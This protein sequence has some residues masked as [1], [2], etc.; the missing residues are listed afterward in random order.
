[1]FA[2]HFF[3]KTFIILIFLVISGCSIVTLGYNRLPFLAILELDSIFDL[4]DEQDKLARIELDAWLEWHRTNHLPRYVVKL[5]EWEKLIL[6]DL[7]PA[8]FCKEVDRKS[9]V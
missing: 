7:T 9:V 4:T 5:Q 6:H 1:M 2:F 3:K 8:Q